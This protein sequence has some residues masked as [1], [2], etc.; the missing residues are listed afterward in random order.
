MAWECE[1]SPSSQAGSAASERG[2]DLHEEKGCRIKKG[3]GLINYTNRIAVAPVLGFI[4]LNFK[5]V[6]FLKRKGMARLYVEHIQNPKCFV[7]KLLF[8]PKNIPSLWANPLRFILWSRPSNT[9]V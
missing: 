3:R 6:I 9:G 7:R 8:S 4:P 2:R 5:T 1:R